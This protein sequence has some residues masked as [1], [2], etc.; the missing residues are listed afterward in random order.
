MKKLVCP[1]F[2][3]NVTQQVLHKDR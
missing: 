2:S 1:T 3:K